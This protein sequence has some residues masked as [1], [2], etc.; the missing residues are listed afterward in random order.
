MSHVVLLAEFHHPAN[1]RHGEVC[2]QGAGLVV[3]TCVEHAAVVRALMPADASLLLED[4][5]L[6]V[7]RTAFEFERRAHA[8]QAAADDR[9]L[10]AARRDHTRVRRGDWPL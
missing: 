10:H 8:D 2:L 5:H 6:G 1:A 4:L 9:E 3:E 7:R